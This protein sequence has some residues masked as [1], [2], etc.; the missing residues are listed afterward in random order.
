MPVVSTK[1]RT[2]AITALMATSLSAG[3]IAFAAVSTGDAPKTAQ[4]LATLY[5]TSFNKKDRA[6]IQKLRY[7]MATKS[8]MQD[9]MDEM[10]EAEMSSGTQYNKF[11]I[12]PVPAGMDKPQM[13]PD[14]VFYKPTIAPTNMVKFISVTKDGSSSTTMPLGMKDGHCYIVT[15]APAAGAQPAFKFGWQ[16]STMPGTTWSV[17]LPNEPEPGRAALEQQGGP[18]ALKDPD[19]YG[20]VKNTA[21]IKTAQHWFWCGE[22]GK[23]VNAADSREKYRAACT[24]YEPET[25]KEWYGDTKKTLDETVDLRLR[26]AEGKLV[27]NKEI[28]LGGAPGREFE[29]LRADK[30]LCLGRV[31]WIKD[32]LFELT[33]ESK[34]DTPDR[35]AAAKFLTSLEVH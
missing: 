9:M 18:D 12:T 4:E 20:V 8:E 24:T 30:T 7:P 16:R 19:A 28:E 2:F 13:G 21:S 26:E 5:M 6:T 3:A 29:I 33:V 14:G 17:L 11:E 35:E 23:R 1:V 10:S 31:Y 25:L 15:V 32:S 27:S 34:K 22:E